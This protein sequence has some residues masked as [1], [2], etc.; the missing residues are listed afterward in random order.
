MEAAWAEIRTRL[1]R[2]CEDRKMATG[3]FHLPGKG[4]VMDFGHR[5]SHAA[6]TVAKKRPTSADRCSDWRDNSEAAPKT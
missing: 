1:D 4:D 2:A 6:R 3:S 5:S